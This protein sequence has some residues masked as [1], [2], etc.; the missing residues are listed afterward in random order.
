MEVV[1]VLL[2]VGL[3]LKRTINHVKEMRALRQ[4]SITET[5]LRDGTFVSV[6]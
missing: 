6:F 3:M 5:F 1:F 4:Y 2:M